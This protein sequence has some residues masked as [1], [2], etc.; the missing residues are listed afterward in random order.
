MQNPMQ[1]RLIQMV[2]D[3]LGRIIPLNEHVDLMPC[4]PACT[5]VLSV[6][7]HAT[8][9]GSQARERLRLFLAYAADSVT[10][11]NH[12]NQSV[13]SFLAKAKILFFWIPALPSPALARAEKCRKVLF[14][15]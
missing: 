15:P 13:G 3:S 9:N 10:M 7:R 2:S 4:F 12:V 11:T 5:G 14:A 6:K 8:K 1:N